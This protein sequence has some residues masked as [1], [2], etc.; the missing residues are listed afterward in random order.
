MSNGLSA[1]GMKGSVSTL[2]CKLQPLV[3]AGWVELTNR[4]LALPCPP[5]ALLA[6]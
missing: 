5:A 3:D 6:A 1:R 4:Q 2:T